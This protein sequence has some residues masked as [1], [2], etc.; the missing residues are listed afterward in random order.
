MSGINSEEP[1]GPQQRNISHPKDATRA[2]SF[3]N[4]LERKMGV[5]LASRGPL[6]GLDLILQVKIESLI[7][8]FLPAEGKPLVE[9][10]FGAEGAGSI[11]VLKKILESQYSAG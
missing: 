5:W 11:S 3:S 7:E 10:S 6:L 2:A 1:P 8:S 4:E 9:K